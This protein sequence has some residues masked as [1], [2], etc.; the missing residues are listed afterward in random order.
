M[1][2]FLVTRPS[3]LTGKIQMK[4]FSDHGW[5]RMDTD[6]GP[7]VSGENRPYQTMRPLWKGFLREFHE[8]AL[9]EF[10]VIGEIR[11]SPRLFYP[12]PSVSIRGKNPLRRSL[13]E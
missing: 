1:T 12:C 6:E 3:P 10:A 9:N 8:L 4:C 2:S 11:V 7:E 5:T 13:A